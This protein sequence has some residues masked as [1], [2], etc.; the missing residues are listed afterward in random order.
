MRKKCSSH[1]RRQIREALGR[2]GEGFFSR[3]SFHI[4]RKKQVH[5]RRHQARQKG[6]AYQPADDDDSQ[7]RIEL[8]LL[9]DQW[10]QTADGR[11]GRKDDG[12]EADFTRFLNRLDQT[13]A[14]CTKLIREVDQE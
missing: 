3:L 5:D 13:L 1:R 4:R 6:G 9:D 2:F 8:V 11:E 12:N 7:G 14:L 10:Q